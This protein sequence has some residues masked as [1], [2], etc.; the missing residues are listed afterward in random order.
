[1]RDQLA[2]DVYPVGVLSDLRR[3]RSA[4]RHRGIREAWRT[5]HYGF[6]RHWR[7]RNAWNGYLAEVDGISHCG[8]GWTRKR[9]LRSLNR[10]IA[11]QQWMRHQCGTL[12]LSSSAVRSR[13][14]VH[15]GSCTRDGWTV[16]AAAEPV[17]S[18]KEEA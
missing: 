4:L 12:R 15:C 5:L 7:S 6:R 16:V 14:C 13:F 3:A 17:N 1:M 10:I 18:S 2:A 11:G 9:A 8:H